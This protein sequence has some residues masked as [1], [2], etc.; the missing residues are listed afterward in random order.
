MWRSV[1][2]RWSLPL[3]FSAKSRCRD[4]NTCCFFCCCRYVSIFSSGCSACPLC[5][6]VPSQVGFYLFVF[7][8]HSIFSHADPPST[9]N[10]DHPLP[11]TME[12]LVKWSRFVG[13]SLAISL[14]KTKLPTLSSGFAPP[15]VHLL[16]TVHI[17]NTAAVSLK[18][19]QHIYRAFGGFFFFFWK[20]EEEGVAACRDGWRDKRVALCL[21]SSRM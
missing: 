7:A 15:T 9:S 12:P 18:S 14:H 4:K 3:I 5:F 10:S 8:F 11:H 21:F 17:K 2:P 13:R 1:F 16:T 6:L 20:G 19:L